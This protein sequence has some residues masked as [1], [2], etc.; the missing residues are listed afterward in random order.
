MI[1]IDGSYGEGGGQILRSAIA[2]STIT[3]E[4]IEIKNIRAKRSNPGL[5]AQ[6]IASLEILAKLSNAE[7]HNLTIGADTIRFIPKEIKSKDLKFDIGTAGSIS[8]VLQAAIPAI[9]LSGNYVEL[10][11]IGGTDVKWSPTMDYVRFV[12]REA[13][14]AIG[15][16]FDIEIVKRGYYPKGGG[17]VKCIVKPARLRSIQFTARRA[18]PKMISVCSLLPKHVAE[19]QIAAALARLERS[20]IM[21]NS[22]TISIEQ[23]L[24]PGSS[25]LVYAT[26][27]YGQFIGGD[28]IGEKGKSAESVGLTAAENFI[29]PY[30]NNA[31]VDKHLADMLVLPLSRSNEVSTFTVDEVTTHLETN[32][33][34]VKQIT[35]CEYS[36]KKDSNYVITIN[37]NRV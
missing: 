14:K 10:E 29:R 15:I 17:I 25:I 2:L 3:R 4:P 30:L 32:L 11:L 34:I 8:M 22:Y 36:I 31:S 20:N 7:V 16:E 13:Y 19:R 12:L 33:Y 28:S 23:S 21:C 24:S 18:E 35:N 1:T 5:R 9:S 26:N 27:E 37:P 6:H